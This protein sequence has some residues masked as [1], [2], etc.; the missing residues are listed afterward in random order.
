[1]AKMG[2]DINF[3]SCSKR[4]DNAEIAIQEPSWLDNKYIEQFQKEIFMMHDPMTTDAKRIQN[5]L[6]LK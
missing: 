3:S 4:W 2:L 5:I 1:M 6:D